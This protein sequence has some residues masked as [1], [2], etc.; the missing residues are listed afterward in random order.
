MCWIMIYC[1]SFEVV[2]RFLNNFLHYRV[3]DRVVLSSIFNIVCL[4]AC[5]LDDVSVFDVF[6]SKFL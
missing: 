2:I 1:L 5:L 6:L 4:L 3:F